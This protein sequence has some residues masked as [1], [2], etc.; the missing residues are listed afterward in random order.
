MGCAWSSPEQ[1]YSQDLD[2]V[3]Q[4]RRIRE[5]GQ[6]NSTVNTSTPLAISGARSTPFMD[7]LRS[8]SHL[9]NLSQV[10]MSEDGNI[11]SS[12]AKVVDSHGVISREASATLGQIRN[13]SFYLGT[14]AE[15][16]VLEDN[17]TFPPT[18]IPLTKQIGKGGYGLIFLGEHDGIT[19]AVKAVHGE[20]YVRNLPECVLEGDEED[21]D[22]AAA[23]V[24]I[25]QQTRDEQMAQ[26]EA[27]L[28][29]L[30]QHENIVTT[31]KILSCFQLTD[32]K[33]TTQMAKTY[34]WFIIMEYC[35]VGSLTQA[36]TRCT[37]HSASMTV[38]IEPLL[39]WDAWG[40]LETLK[41]V[42]RALMYL[43]SN[44]ILHGDLKAG[45]VLLSSNNKDRRRFV[46][47]ISYML[48]IT[49]TKTTCSATCSASQKYDSYMFSYMLSI[50]KDNSYMFSYMLSIMKD[51]SYMFSYMLS[52]MKDNSYMFSYML[53]IMKDNSYM[54]SYMLSIMKDNSYMFS[55]MLSITK[56]DS[57]MFSFMLS[58]TKD[59]S[60][61]FSFM[62]S[63]TKDDSYMFSFMLSITKDDSYMFSFM[64]SITKDD[65]YMFSFMLSITK[66]DS[67]MFSFMLSITKDDSYMFS[68]ML[69]ITRT[70]FTFTKD[71]SYM[72]SFMLSITKDDSYM[73]SF[74]LS[75]TKDDSYMFS[76]MLSIIKDN[77]CM[78]S[79]MLS[80][81]KDDSYMFSFML[82]IIKDNSYMFSCMLSMSKR[83]QLHVQLHAQH[84]LDYLVSLVCRF[85]T[86]SYLAKYEGG[87]HQVV[88]NRYTCTLTSS[89]D[90][91]SMGML[92]WEIY[93]SKAV[94]KQL[95]DNEVI[96][97]VVNEQLR[98]SFP[99]DVP[100]SY[101]ALAEWC[102]TENHKER[103]TLVEVLETLN[104]VQLKLCPQGQDSDKMVLIGQLPR[105]SRAKKDSSATSFSS[106][107]SVVDARSHS[108]TLGLGIKLE[109]A[110]S[111]P[112][113]SEDVSRKELRPSQG[114]ADRSTYSNTATVPDSS[115]GALA[116]GSLPMH[117]IGSTRELA[118]SEISFAPHASPVALPS[119]GPPSP[120]ATPPMGRPPRGPSDSGDHAQKRH[121][122][123]ASQLVVSNLSAVS[124]LV[125]NSVS[126]FVAS[127]VSRPRSRQQ[128]DT[129]GP[130]PHRIS[131]S[132]SE[133]SK[134]SDKLPQ[135]GNGSVQADKSGAELPH[136][137]PIFIRTISAQHRY[138]NKN[139]G[140][141]R[142]SR[143]G[144]DAGAPRSPATTANSSSIEGDH[145]SKKSMASGQ[146]L[147]GLQ[148]VYS[149]RKNMAP[150]HTGS[151][152]DLHSPSIDPN[153]AP[154]PSNAASKGRPCAPLVIHGQHQRASDAGGPD[155]S[156][157]FSSAQLDD[158]PQIGWGS[159][160]E[161][162]NSFPGVDS[163]KAA[164]AFPKLGPATPKEEP[165]AA[166]FALG[167]VG[168]Q[169][170]R[171]FSTLGPV[172]DRRAETFLQRA[173][174]LRRAEGLE[175]ENNRYMSKSMSLDCRRTRS[176]NHQVPHSSP[177]SGSSPR[178]DFVSSDMQAAAAA[179]IA[180]T[181]SGSTLSPMPSLHLDPTRTSGGNSRRSSRLGRL[182]SAPATPSVLAAAA[183][184]KAQV[185]GPNPTSPV[186]IELS[187]AAPTS[188]LQTSPAQLAKA[189]LA[190]AGAGK[191]PQHTKNKDSR[192]RSTATRKY[193]DSSAFAKGTPSTF[194]V[195]GGTILSSP[196]MAGAT[197]PSP[198]MAGATLSSPVTSG[199]TLSSPQ[200]AGTT[201]L[202]PAGTDSSSSWWQTKARRASNLTSPQLSPP[203]SMC[204]SLSNPPASGIVRTSRGSPHSSL[205]KSEEK[206][207]R[208]PTRKSS[209]L[210]SSHGSKT[211]MAN[212]PTFVKTPQEV[213]AAFGIPTAAESRKNTEF[214]L[215]EESLPSMRFS[216]KGD[217]TYG[218]RG[219]RSYLNEQELTAPHI[220]IE[221]L[222]RH[223][224]K[225][226]P[227]VSGE[228]VAKGARMKSSLS[229]VYETD[230]ADEL[231]FGTPHNEHSRRVTKQ[232][233]T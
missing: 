30:M 22:D 62:L 56:D 6:S 15:Q 173:M 55:Y 157:T 13:A 39:E 218:E 207:K 216:G 74:M 219:S 17:T 220:S 112:L 185:F 18:K 203:H 70:T 179:A 199:A 137:G 222:L 150:V 21:E 145:S 151:H 212:S 24:N 206:E 91:Y 58:I 9:P 83:Q 68:F 25:D 195:E 27:V 49:E 205:G 79:F 162:D 71:D 2:H 51:N 202:S 42:V 1:V 119:H 211:S 135:S 20:K 37:F 50:M 120:W 53:S 233:L 189:T 131:H 81:T 228:N 177:N 191:L 78:F 193:E 93:S 140:P 231:T 114:K 73:F 115:A 7:E 167:R 209:W 225:G 136:T 210:Y 76:F 125:A 184:A 182:S 108:Q 153:A 12:L 32:A 223:L 63:I 57:Y 214:E 204:S 43:H 80:I 105:S 4:R 176:T 164:S 146:G 66:D 156:P 98:P 200:T 171:Q 64:L 143:A 104:N 23:Q 147:Q 169:P 75:I 160:S 111:R 187:P 26:L 11:S 61:M 117:S 40:A 103:P 122:V 161:S 54:F 88:W 3:F 196:Q 95:R 134:P 226:S 101:K 113:S 165:R 123:S 128:S 86:I 87:D 227:R 229:G 121:G 201:L 67:Y 107:V 102:W 213:K 159:E 149:S 230:G 59:D 19:V 31:F 217:V 28:M 188:N 72:F 129:G 16:M 35:S 118:T 208:K 41:E 215:A 96:I 14:G 60:Y 29:S 186:S 124:H 221:G 109:N 130:A 144:Q 90:V 126:H 110:L 163:F 175:D 8:M 100:P 85:W 190:P 155:L 152:S 10:S 92:M 48:S 139:P 154:P 192:M 106:S 99:Q 46:A 181:S 69:S 224:P 84:I 138:N 133:H 116:S 197:L 232:E 45:N 82:S 168:A 166:S 198:P 183:A 172:V 36:L 178:K 5:P 94:H 47:K 141:Q 127:S 142:T 33:D 132:G 44:G 180:A 38:G 89:C 77:S 170:N 194:S 174:S 148:G 34:Q 52:I 97:Q 65:S 158:L